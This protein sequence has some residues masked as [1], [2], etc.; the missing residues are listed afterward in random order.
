M[1]TSLL[2]AVLCGMVSLASA[3][4]VSGTLSDLDSLPASGAIVN[5]M[6]ADT[7]ETI[8]FALADENGYW[9]FE[10]VKK[11]DWIVMAH[12]MGLEPIYKNITIQKGD[13]KL[14]LPMRFKAKTFSLPEIMVTANKLGLVKQGDKYI[15]Q[16]DSFLKGGERNLEDVIKDLPGFEIKPDGTIYFNNKQ[17][18]VVTLDE[19]DLFLGIHKIATEGINAKDIQELS[20][21]TGGNPNEQLNKRPSHLDVQLKEKA[22]NKFLVTEE[23]AGG[24]SNRWSLNSTLLKVNDKLGFSIVAKANNTGEALLTPLDM[25]GLETSLIRAFMKSDNLEDVL[26]VP[27]E[28]K[29]QIGYT[30]KKNYM[31]LSALDYGP[32]QSAWHNKI[33]YLFAGQH[34]V[35]DSIQVGRVL[36][37][38]SEAIEGTSLKQQTLGFHHLRSFNQYSKGKSTLS[39]EF[40]LSLRQ[41]D[42]TDKYDFKYGQT[43]FQEYNKKQAQQVTFKPYILLDMKLDSLSHWSNEINAS[44]QKQDITRDIA[45]NIDLFGTT[46]QTIHQ[47][48]QQLNLN[49]TLESEYKRQFNQSDFTITGLLGHQYE[50]FEVVSVLNTLSPLQIQ[51][52]KVGM[53]MAYSA[54]VGR[55]RFNNRLSS[56]AYRRAAAGQSTFYTP[57]FNLSSRIMYKYSDLHFMTLNIKRQSSFFES[58]NLNTLPIAL[59]AVQLVQNRIPLNT[60]TSLNSIGLNYQNKNVAANAMHSVGLTYSYNENALATKLSTNAQYYLEE[61]IVVPHSQTLALSVISRA[62]ITRKLTYDLSLSHNYFWGYYASAA[63]LTPIS[64]SNLNNALSLEYELNKHFSASLAY[65]FNYSSQL[66]QDLINFKAKQ[67]IPEASLKYQ[68]KRFQ[69]ELRLKYNQMNSIVPIR[70]W[71]LGGKLSYTINSHFSVALRATNVLYMNRFRNTLIT[72]G[73]YYFEYKSYYEQP[74]FALLELSYRL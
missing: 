67:H 30:K 69:G 12:S 20:M 18:E 71:D 63:G 25:L 9:A 13:D 28:A 33:A 60:L 62:K 36:L 47:T 43:N 59:S 10:S 32:K 27:E 46:A 4:M 40:P 56:L 42:F 3:Q 49:Q 35:S 39:F 21:D 15:F 24:Y 73:V 7:T 68:R 8:D 48:Q 65:Q 23:W 1:R 55:F 14:H 26:K 74:G 64:T 16:V 34:N 29:P 53:T 22:K 19:R 11:G 41:E 45:A 66:S 38:S 57:I 61:K 72:P 51:T 5:L 17:V 6:S 2:I 44:W 58:T 31:V 52:S 50:R 54:K 37:T 70:Y